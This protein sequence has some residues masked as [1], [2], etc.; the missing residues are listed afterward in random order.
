MSS[1]DLQRLELR[2]L[3]TT[4]S[5]W[6]GR[7][8][9]IQRRNVRGLLYRLAAE[10]GPIS[11]TQLCLLFWPDE[12]ELVAR[13]NLTHLL[14]HLRM[15]LPDPDLLQTRAENIELDAR[16]VWCDVVA[17]RLILQGDKKDADQL[18][19]A[20]DLYRGPFLAGFLLPN[21]AEFE[22]W[23]STLQSTLERLYLEALE[24]LIDREIARQNYEQARLDALR[25]L[26]TDD[27]AEEI[28]RKL[29]ALFS[30]NW[31]P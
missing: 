3:G 28:H 18:R 24:T 30:Y 6:E 27:L 2:L 8:L 16:S 21:C 20:V 12:P 7:P 1:T 14:T 11:R 22:H 13:R 26:E 19:L 17:F 9:A 29:I 31:R 4:K 25:Y 23:V 10:P 15:A 5:E